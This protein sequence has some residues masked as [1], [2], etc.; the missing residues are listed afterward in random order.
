MHLYATGRCVNLGFAVD[1]NGESR[2]DGV[3]GERSRCSDR[4]QE[5]CSGHELH[6]VEMGDRWPT[7]AVVMVHGDLRCGDKLVSYRPT[8]DSSSN[9]APPTTYDS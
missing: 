1:G 7:H 4:L 3:K 6:I 5:R 9:G 2:A 8:F